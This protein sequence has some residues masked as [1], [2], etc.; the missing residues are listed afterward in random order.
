M[1]TLWNNFFNKEQPQQNIPTPSNK[2]QNELVYSTSEFFFP[3]TLKNLKK[4]IR[5]GGRNRHGHVTIRARG[6]GAMKKYRL[7]DFDRDMATQS[8]IEVLKI[9]HDP[10]RSAKIALC[11]AGSNARQFY[12]L[13][14]EGLKEGDILYG[15]DL[16]AGRDPLTIGNRLKIKDIPVGTK[17]HSI[18]RY[19]NQGAKLVRAAGTF[20]EILKKDEKSLIQL[21]SKK[22]I[23]ISGSCLATIGILSNVEHRYKKMSKAG[24]NRWRGRRPKV[25]GTAM[26]PIDHPHGGKTR[27]AGKRGNQPRT[28]WGRLAKWNKK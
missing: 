8:Q 17:I 16:L 14:H 27:V 24:E 18:E 15:K 10:N 9:Q 2:E 12:I 25:R 11:Q 23:E 5:I 13:A 1:A 7:I 4:K 3:K 22:K 26:N 19:P 21:P 20:A 6:G 28:K